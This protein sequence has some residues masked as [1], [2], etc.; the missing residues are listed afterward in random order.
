LKSRRAAFA[1][2]PSGRSC[3][4]KD[5]CTRSSTKRSFAPGSGDAADY[6]ILQTGCGPGDV[7]ELQNAIEQAIA[8]GSSDVILPENLPGL[9]PAH[10]N[11]ANGGSY[12]QRLDAARRTVLIQEFAKGGGIQ[13]VSERL[14]LNSKSVYR[15]LHQLQPR[16]LLKT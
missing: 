2:H 15:L 6:R 3:C 1:S 9:R 4:R 7:R 14:E 12:E 11:G 8:I 13:E 16:H 10:G 5:C